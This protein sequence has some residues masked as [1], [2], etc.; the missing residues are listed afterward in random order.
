MTWGPW[1]A[2]KA[3]SA[4]TIAL[5]ACDYA[6]ESLASF[7]GITTPKYYF[8]LEEYKKREAERKALEEE[9][10][11]WSEP[12]NVSEQDEQTVE[13]SVRSKQP[14]KTEMSAV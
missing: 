5:A 13:E 2:H 1:F 9:R 12:A 8:E 10:K 6:G 11:G 14:L 3:W 7:F 4:G